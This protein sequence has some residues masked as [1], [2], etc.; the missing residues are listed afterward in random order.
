MRKY[1]I[2]IFGRKDCDK[3]KAINHKV[4]ELIKLDKFKS[5]EKEYIDVMSEDGLVMFCDFEC[6]NAQRIPSLVVLKS[7]KGDQFQPIDN[8]DFDKNELCKG[9]M[10][11]QHL[12]LQTD[13]S[14][15]DGK[16]TSKM[17]ESI[18]DTAIAK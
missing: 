10:T 13:Y 2:I 18:L 3:C 12:G 9:F 11:Y 4:D 7:E 16:I 1:K 8:N 5:F 14:I 17:I 15:N 6:L